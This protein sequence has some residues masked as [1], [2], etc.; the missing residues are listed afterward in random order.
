MLVLVA[1]PI[2]NLGDITFRAVETLKQV[3]LIAAEDTRRTRILTRHYGIATPLTSYHEHN[4]RRKATELL[5][6][7]ADGEDIALVSDAGTP[8][9]SDP[10]Y[11]LVRMARDRGIPVTALPGPCALVTALS[12]S[13][14]PTDAFVFVGFPP[15]KGAARRRMLEAFC[16]EHRTVILYESPYRLVKTLTDI[17]A[18]LGDPRVACARELTKVFEEVCCGR[19]S[20]LAAHYRAHPPKGECVVLI[21]RKEGAR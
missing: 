2:G 21:D 16:T 15:T 18:I 14:L 9:I 17:D 6:R 3:D 7:L 10:G 4:E 11:R 19:A 20:E 13:G 1:T 5:Q 8:G 12:I